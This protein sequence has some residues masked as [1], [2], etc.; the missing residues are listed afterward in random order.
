[1]QGLGWEGLS[2]LATCKSEQIYNHSPLPNPSRMLWSLRHTKLLFNRDPQLGNNFAYIFYYFI[3]MSV[4][5]ICLSVCHAH[6]RGSQ[7]R[8]LDP[9]EL[10]LEMV[11]SCHVGA[12]N[13]IQ[14]F[15]KSGK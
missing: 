5:P 12:G 8:S 15:C 7:K 3:Y 13:K 14:V 1:M 11:V 4:L 6:A 10:Q 9:L 2:G